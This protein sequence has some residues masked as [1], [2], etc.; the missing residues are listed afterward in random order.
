MTSD[1]AIAF[2]RRHGVVLESARGP[3]PNLADTVAGEEIAGSW[4]GHPRGDEIFGLTKAVRKCA[5]VLVCRLVDGKITYVHRRLWPALARIADRLDERRLAAVHEVHT[6]Q[7]KHKATATAFESWLPAAI[8]RS[9][10]ALSTAEATA[11]LGDWLQLKAEAG[12]KP[13]T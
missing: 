12:S 8:R 6:S 7:G 4:W 13:A 5:D 11:A 3:V 2:V 1:E 10:R 9:A